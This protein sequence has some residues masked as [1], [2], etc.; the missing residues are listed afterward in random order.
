MRSAATKRFVGLF[1][2]LAFLSLRVA[3]AHT[4]SHVTED[5]NDHHCELCEI[6]T[7]SQELTPFEGGNENATLSSPF[8]Y[9]ETDD[10]NVGYLEPIL[11]IASPVFIY[12]KPPPRG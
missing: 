7:V 3:N 12:N 9:S 10:V 1:F 11:L 6:I 2:L 4:I 5:G 8:I